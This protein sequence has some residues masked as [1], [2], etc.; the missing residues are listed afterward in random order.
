M[1]YGKIRERKGVGDDEKIN[2]IFACYCYIF[3]IVRSG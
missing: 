1:K 3:G 2:I